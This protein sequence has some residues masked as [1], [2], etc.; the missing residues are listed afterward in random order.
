VEAAGFGASDAASTQRM[1][2]C[3]GSCYAPHCGPC[4]EHTACHA[5][6]SSTIWHL[7]SCSCVFTACVAM[8]T[9]HPGGH[10][11]RGSVAAA[12]GRGT[13]CVPRNMTVSSCSIGWSTASHVLRFA[14]RMCVG[15]A[16]DFDRRVEPRTARRPRRRV[17]RWPSLL[18]QQ[19]V[20]VRAVLHGQAAGRAAPAFEPSCGS[21]SNTFSPVAHIPT[22]YPTVLCKCLQVPSGII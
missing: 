13:G 20:Y 7:A 14:G 8:G 19:G 10:C 5:V 16:V 3:G 21:A 4:P 12:W 2:G 9:H 1:A 6:H 18:N 17:C 15:D 22:T 11:M